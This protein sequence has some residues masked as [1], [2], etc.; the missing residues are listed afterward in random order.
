M[1]I[2]PKYKIHLAAAKSD[3][4]RPT[5][6]SVY[7]HR[8]ATTGEPVAVATDGHILAIVPVEPSRVPETE[9]ELPE[10]PAAGEP[11]IL[12]PPD[13]IKHAGKKDNHGLLLVSTA[14]TPG[15]V[16][17]VDGRGWALPAVDPAR[18]F[19]AYEN[20]VPQIDRPVKFRVSFDARL[21]S[22]LADAIGADK[23]AVTLEF[24]AGEFDA[25]RV[26]PIDK[27]GKRVIDGEGVLMPM[28]VK[29]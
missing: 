15:H 5:L 29:E 19:P 8:R 18:P 1:I 17:T 24:G 16:S 25:I 9:D 28:I 23:G 20:V 11:G 27:D 2:D 7:V 21:L 12:I 6:E 22:R 4:S 14:D 26:L 3:A 13:A 10:I